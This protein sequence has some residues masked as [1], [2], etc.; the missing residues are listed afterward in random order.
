MI[1]EKFGKIKIVD[2][3][4]IHELLSMEM[5]KVGRCEDRHEFNGVNLQ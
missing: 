3:S 1:K 2:L 5:S 4:I